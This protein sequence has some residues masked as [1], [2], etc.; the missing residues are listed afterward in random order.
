MFRIQI[1]LFYNTYGSCSA[2]KPFAPFKFLGT[3]LTGCSQ[4]SSKSMKLVSLFLRECDHKSQLDTEGQA[5]GSSD[6]GIKAVTNEAEQAKHKYASTASTQLCRRISGRIVTPSQ[7]FLAEFAFVRRLSACCVF[8]ILV[9]QKPPLQSKKMDYANV[10]NSQSPPPGSASC[11][12]LGGVRLPRCSS[13][14]LHNERHLDGS[15]VKA[16]DLCVSVAGYFLP[17]RSQCFRN[18]HPC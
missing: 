13:G 7:W 11:C 5:V 2:T 6:R 17:R 4:V 10:A 18:L 8:R 12:F 15:K 14:V 9:L 16:H 3:R 1:C